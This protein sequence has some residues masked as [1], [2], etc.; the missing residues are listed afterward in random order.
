MSRE[1]L[2]LEKLDNL[3]INLSEWYEPVE[4]AEEEISIYKA[5]DRVLSQKLTVNEDLPPFDRSAVDGYALK[6]SDTH[7][8]SETHPAY[9]HV[10][11]EVKMGEEAKFSLTQGEAAWIA[12]GAMLPDG[13]DC[14]VMVENTDRISPSRIEVYDDLAP[15]QNVIKQGDDVKGGEE[16][17]S[18]GQRIRAQD[19]GAMAGLGMVK[20]GVFQKPDIALLSTGDEIVPPEADKKAGEIRDINT[21]ALSALYEKWGGPIGESVIVE[22]EPERLRNKIEE[23]LDRDIIVISG[24]SSVGTRDFTIDVIEELGEPGVLLHGLAVKPGKPTILGRVSNTPVLGL[25]GNPASAWVVSCIV[26]PDLIN[27]MRGIAPAEPEE[28]KS[29]AKLGSLKTRI[30]SARGKDEFIP[31]RFIND[32]EVLLTG[33]E[34][35]VKKVAPIPGKSNLITTLVEAQGFIHISAGCE[36]LARGSPVRVYP[37]DSE[38]GL[39]ALG[40]ADSHAGE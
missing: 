29:Q 13:A 4:L 30:P 24:G 16:L 26:L 3:H 8:A 22:D 35:G 20:V 9:F 31:V 40:R 36:G 25:P 11:K 5:A 7:G 12:T 39:L 28:L 32:E 27:V 6:A 14:C 23:N 10:E 38:A 15:G 2:E 18:A 33:E 34:I 17:L 19:I 21:P 37:L 1:F